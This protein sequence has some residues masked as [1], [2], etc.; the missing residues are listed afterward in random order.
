MQKTMLS[1][2]GIDTY[3]LMSSASPLPTLGSKE[4]NTILP[5]AY[6]NY[7]IS[8]VCSAIITIFAVVTAHCFTIRV[9]GLV[10]S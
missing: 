9:G 7:I 2:A 3:A 10:K 5:E 4:E 8:N 6:D 1:S